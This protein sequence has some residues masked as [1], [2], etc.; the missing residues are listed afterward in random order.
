MVVHLNLN[1]YIAEYL[2][3]RYDPEN[4]LKGN[5]ILANQRSRIAYYLIPYLPGNVDSDRK[6]KNFK[7]QFSHN[8]IH[9]P[10][11]TIYLGK[12]NELRFNFF[13][14]NMFMTEFVDYVQTN[15]IR[16][17]LQQKEETRQDIILRFIEAHGISFDHDADIYET[18]K[19]R[20]YRFYKLK[21]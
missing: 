16:N 13:V 17:F 21:I 15:R 5:T 18:L 1:G 11:K 2:K 9:I 4:L 20:I 19:K 3:H 10:D 12:T 14:G 8:P 6:S 7:I